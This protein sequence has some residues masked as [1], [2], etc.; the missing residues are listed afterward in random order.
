MGMGV[1]FHW[2]GWFGLLLSDGAPGLGSLRTLQR[3]PGW[4]PQNAP[5]HL[6]APFAGG[7]LSAGVRQPSVY[8]SINMKAGSVLEVR[9]VG[10]GHLEPAAPAP[11]AINLPIGFPFD[12]PPSE[13]L[14]TII[15]S[16][17]SALSPPGV[18]FSQAYFRY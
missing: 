2:R 6:T 11:P 16:N 10:F 13:P 4:S 9:N 7:I 5:N 17:R 8:G 14:N 12:I 1:P 3:W 15:T 18:T